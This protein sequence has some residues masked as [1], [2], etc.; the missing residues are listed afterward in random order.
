MI[1]TYVM[2][3]LVFYQYGTGLISFGYC[4]TSILDSV[5]G[6]FV[7]YTVWFLVSKKWDFKN[8]SNIS[9]SQS[10]AGCVIH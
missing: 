4:A 10:C 8:I 3:V 6:T 5:V 2:Y 1:V 7:E 9:T